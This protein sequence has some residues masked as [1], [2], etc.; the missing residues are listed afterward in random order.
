M[1][2]SLAILGAPVR[3]A[4]ED[5][6]LVKEETE[7][8]L[9][10]RG[11]VG[12]IAGSILA[13]A[14][15]ANP[16]APLVG[17][18]V[19]FLVGK[20]SDFSR[21]KDAEDE[22]Q[23]FTQRSIVPVGELGSFA[24]LS[25]AGEPGTLDLTGGSGPAIIADDERDLTVVATPLTAGAVVP[26]EDATDADAAPRSVAPDTA[27]K[28]SE[29]PLHLVVS[30]PA[31]RDEVRLQALREE[32]VRLSAEPEFVPHARCPEGQAPRYRKKVAVT[33]FGLSRPAEASMGALFDAERQVPQTLYQHLSASRKVQTFS[34]SE[35]RLYASLGD[36]ATWQR[37]D[38]RLLRESDLSR[39]MGVQFVV[40]GV[41]RDMGLEEARAWDTSVS[42][43]LR[44]RVGRANQNRQFVLDVVVHDGFTGL[45]V[46]EERYTTRGEWTLPQQQRV[47][48]GSPAFYETPYGEAVAELMEQV[49]RDVI[50]QLDCQPLMAQVIEADQTVLTLDAGSLAGLKPGD[51]LR[52]LRRE[53]PVALRDGA[54]RLRDTG[55]EVTLEQVG[56]DSSFARMPL[57][58]GRVNVQQGD[59]VVVW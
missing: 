32:L 4:A 18:V 46:Y 23:A 58:A 26:G 47:G 25:L 28:T 3:A 57:Q 50:D 33:G 27:V 56:L 31:T 14:A 41:I 22:Q 44:R 54:T 9:S 20:H 29:H 11:R 1:A 48:F 6:S 13:G 55:V 35:Q 39:E 19:G 51:T 53:S 5:R 34:A 15:V 38:N 45:P 49:S 10:D 42:S 12:A 17:N 21:K 2:L 37:S 40:A 16:F 24:S 30:K 8:F 43:Q 36:G 52:L 7:D 59:V